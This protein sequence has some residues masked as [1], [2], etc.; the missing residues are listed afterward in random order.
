MD[1]VFFRRAFTTINCI[2]I[3]YLT[4]IS[5]LGVLL[6]QRST[7]SHT[8][9]WYHHCFRRRLAV[10]WFFQ[11]Y[12]V[13]LKQTLVVIPFFKGIELIRNSSS[14]HLFDEWPSFYYKRV[15]AATYS[16][17]FTVFLQN[18][19]C[20]KEISLILIPNWFQACIYRMKSVI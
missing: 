6:F 15:I 19:N 14:S 16:F 9:E 13:S 18:R 17:K 20:S 3:M 11:G 7:C 8:F 1:T 10:I 4:D 2:Y 12:C 5:I